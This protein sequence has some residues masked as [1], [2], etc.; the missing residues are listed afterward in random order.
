MQA[1]PQPFIDQMDLFGD[2]FDPTVQSFTKEDIDSLA[3]TTESLKD[4]SDMSDDEKED[5]VNSKDYKKYSMD[6]DRLF[7]QHIDESKSSVQDIFGLS[8]QGASFSYNCFKFLNIDHEYYQDM[9]DSSPI[10]QETLEKGEELLPTFK[11]LHEDIFMSLYQYNVDVLP[12]EKMHMQSYMNRNILSKLLNTPTYIALRKTCRCDM[13]NAG[14]GTEIL[15]EKVFELL[16]TEL[17]K[18]E[19][20]EQKKK[21][22]DELIRQEEELDSLCE[23]QD[24]LLERIDELQQEGEFADQEELNQ[25]QDSLSE[26]QQS[27]EQARALAE[28]QAA[29]CDELVIDDEDEIED[30]EL[31]NTVSVVVSNDLGT[32]MDQVQQ[33]S[34]LVDAWGLGG[35]DTGKRKVP[36]GIKRNV[37]EKIR[38]SKYLTKFT[39][40][41]GRFK[42]TAI[43]ETKKK[44]KST[45]VEVVSVTSGNRLQDALPSDKMNLCNDITKK[46]LY[47]RMSENQ[48]LTY[49]KESNNEKNKGP[50][51]VCVDISGSMGGCYYNYEDPQCSDPIDWAKAMAISILEIAQRQ[52]RNYACIMYD[53]R[54]RQTTVLQKDENSPDKIIE[55]AETESGGGTD[56]VPPLEKSLDLIKESEFKNA[57]IVFITDGECYLPDSFKRKF[58]NIK[59]DKEFKCLG[60]LIDY[61]RSSRTSL[62]E[63]CNSVT[64]ISDIAEANDSNNENNKEIFRSLL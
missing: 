14:I 37:I 2:M 40:V 12:P 51:I 28:Q 48:L 18:I 25:L 8:G 33:V 46:D 47:R 57:D 20:F 15:G 53:D 9:V 6:T 43:A 44:D 30:D 11:Y 34:D 62:K 49:E 23:E 63:F 31:S 1:T 5:F 26:V 3:S 13:F 36:Y 10:M 4:F 21:E 16:E 41:I 7:G 35:S 39:D 55:I 17:K 38:G 58:N 52:K 54:V 60:V 19:S 22:F 27:I 24:D 56:F 64:Y 50:I 59:E 29:K 45:S 42:E 61:H 32:C